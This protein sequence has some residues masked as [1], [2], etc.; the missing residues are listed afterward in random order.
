[1][2]F[3]AVRLNEMTRECMQ[4]EQRRGLR[5]D[6]WNIPILRSWTDKEESANGTEKE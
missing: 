2:L 3:E 5:T 1:M 4:T 6:L